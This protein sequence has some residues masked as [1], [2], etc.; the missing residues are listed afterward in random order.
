MFF[1]PTGLSWFLNGKLRRDQATRGS[2]LLGSTVCLLV[3]IMFLNVPLPARLQSVTFKIP[4]VKI[5]LSIKDQPVSITASGA[6]VWTAKDR[7]MN[8]LNLELDADLSDL[9]Q[10]MTA[11]MSSEL[12]KSDRCADRIEIQNATLTPIEPASRAVVQLHYER[13]AC[14]KVFHKEEAK[15]V[16]GGNAQI[17]MKLT[18]AIEENNT[19]LRLVPEVESIEADHSL[20]E[21]LRSGEVGNMV[22][23]KIR[24][25][26]L[27]AMQKGTNLAATLPPAA[28]GYATIQ[29]A[30]FKATPAGGLMVVLGG[31]V[32]I[33]DEQVQ[34]LS[35]Q[36]K[37]RAGNK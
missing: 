7:N 24:K 9:Q 30:E 4:P 13:W 6:L 26:I 11:L 16:L 37:E 25:A 34:E 27:N 8:V 14:V 10:N 21:L 3:L 22:R 35:K 20:G 12:D 29:K 32:R 18:P 1:I 28:Q 17:Q 19:E 23:E 36:L 15:R 31:Q 33:T 5:P 2:N